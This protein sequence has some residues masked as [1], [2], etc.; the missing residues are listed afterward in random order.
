MGLKNMLRKWLEVPAAVDL[1]IPPG[2]KP[3]TFQPSPIKDATDVSDALAIVG[4]LSGASRPAA[5][6][7]APRSILSPARV[8]DPTNIAALLASIKGD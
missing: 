3:T 6:R 5:P 4:V 2:L 7:H 1:P 8:V